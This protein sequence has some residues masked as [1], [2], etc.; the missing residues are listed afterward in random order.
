MTDLEMS[1]SSTSPESSRG[2]V[3]PS[4]PSNEYNLNLASTRPSP[5]VSRETNTNSYGRPTPSNG[6]S[7]EYNLN[8][9]TS[10]INSR[11]AP[12]NSSFMISRQNTLDSNNG[13]RGVRPPPR[14]GNSPV[15]PILRQ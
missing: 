7:N 13:S 5:G 2:T 8:T 6:P 10:F 3:P 4:N 15:I 9:A 1:Q 14:P 11:E 12:T